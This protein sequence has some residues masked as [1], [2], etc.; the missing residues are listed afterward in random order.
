MYVITKGIVL[1]LLIGHKTQYNIR[2]LWDSQE[3]SSLFI[4]FVGW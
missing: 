2:K 1:E 3:L 4:L